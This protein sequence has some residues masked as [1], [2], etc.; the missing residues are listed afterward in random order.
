[1]HMRKT[2]PKHWKNKQNHVSKIVNGTQAGE[3]F[4]LKLA[5]LIWNKLLIVSAPLQLF[6][7]G[8]EY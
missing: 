8:L 1:M 7:L 3:N 4:E 2:A 5:F 6:N